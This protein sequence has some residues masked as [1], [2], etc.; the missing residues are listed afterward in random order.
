MFGCS[1]IVFDN[2]LASRMKITYNYIIQGAMD[3]MRM[4]WFKPQLYRFSNLING[5]MYF[6]TDL[7]CMLV[8]VIKL[9]T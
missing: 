2:L 6:L 3:L 8:Y 9:R 7:L 1:L 5:G 4:S